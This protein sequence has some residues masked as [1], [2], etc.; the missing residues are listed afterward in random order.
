MIEYVWVIPLLPLL[1]VVINTFFGEMLPRKVAAWLAAG[2][3]GIGALLSL[4]V[5]ADIYS[6][7]EEFTGATVELYRWMTAGDFSVNVAFFVDQLSALMLIVVTG[8]GF[9]I[10]A[11][12]IGYMAHDE[13]IRRF[14]IYLNLFIFAM[15]MLVLGDNYLLMFLGWEGVGLCSYLLVSFWFTDPNNAA[16]GNKAFVVNRIGD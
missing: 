4:G 8:V 1:G 5:I 12:S 6:R 2:L 15:L 13:G 7:G 16:A 3:V 9:L 14:F 11:Y 10:H